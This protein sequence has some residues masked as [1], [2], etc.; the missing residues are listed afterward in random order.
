MNSR[1]ADLFYE[2]V[3]VNTSKAAVVC[4]DDIVTYGDLA[5]LSNKISSYLI[6][7]G[8]SKGDNVAVLLDTSSTYVA[9]FIS[10]ADLGICLVPLNPTL[11]NEAIEIAVRACDVKHIFSDDIF[12]ASH[13]RAN[14]DYVSGG[15]FSIDDIEGTR[16]RPNICDIDGTENYILTMTSG[17]TDFPKPICITQDIKLRRIEYHVDAFS[18]S[19][20]DII[21]VSTPLYHS[22][23]ERMLLISLTQ[24][25]TVLLL[26]KFDVNTW[27]EKSNNY[28]VTFS[29]MTSIEI[30]NLF[31][32]QINIPNT[33]RAI[34]SSSSYLDENVKKGFVND[35][36]EF[37][38]I[39]GTSET[40]TLTLI[41]I[42]KHEG[43]MSSVGNSIKDVDIRVVRDENSTDYD[44]LCVAYEIGEIVCKTP[45]V[46][47]GYYNQNMM[48]K[49]QFN[50]GYF[51]TG[52]LG[53]LDENGYLYYAGRRKEIINVGAMLVFPKDVDLIVSSVPGVRECASFAYIDDN[54][55]ETVAIAIVV[56]EDIEFDI[57]SV[58][59]K[60]KKR[61]ADY[62][63]PKKYFIL[64]R[65]PKNTMGKVQRN[66]I[67][68]CLVGKCY[69]H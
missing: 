7:N 17:S 25:A 47:K 10:A 19:D 52:D 54:K 29:I 48:W 64:D 34:V 26:N 37:Y 20:N 50:E 4:G 31:R 12:F 67:S 1:I 41:N 60:C 55:N 5:N 35:N 23:A 68:E 58:K 33:Y 53:Y 38:E 14:F 11:S 63:Q 62:Q 6:S 59:S 27:L 45:L 13:L 15:I 46:C 8:V 22:L 16:E 3:K 57:N 56:D 40:S 69:E 42:S 43:K 65:L 32:E 49:S 61:L 30:T 21:M 28:K 44:T 36:F 18:I 2:K 24:G 51:R 9:L 39:Y 66:K